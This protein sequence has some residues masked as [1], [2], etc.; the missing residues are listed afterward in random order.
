MPKGT[1]TTE[2]LATM[3]Q[4]GFASMQMHTD[5]RFTT[6]EMELAAIRRQLHHAIYQREF[7]LLE[8]RVSILEQKAKSRKK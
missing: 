1:I 8:K 6:I 5:K 3:V 7:V 4:Q 2:K